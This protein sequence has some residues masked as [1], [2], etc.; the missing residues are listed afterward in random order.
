MQ[1]GNVIIK[2]TVCADSGLNLSHAVIVTIGPIVL[3][4]ECFASSE[5]RQLLKLEVESE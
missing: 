5:I 1:I 3:C 4:V 2:N